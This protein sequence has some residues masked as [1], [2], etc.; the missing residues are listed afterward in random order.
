VL[1][2][3]RYFVDLSISQAKEMKMETRRMLNGLL[4]LTL[5]LSTLL[6]GEPVQTKAAPESREAEPLEEIEYAMRPVHLGETSP[7]GETLAQEK[8]PAQPQDATDSLALTEI[9]PGEGTNNVTT[10]ITLL[11]QGFPT[12]DP[13]TVTLGITPLINVR[14][15]SS[16]VLI[17]DVPMSTTLGTHDVAV[18]NHL[19]ESASLAAAFD[20][21]DFD[22]TAVNVDYYPINDG[23]FNLY[24][25][26]IDTTGDH[27]LWGVMGTDDTRIYKL[28]LSEAVPGTSAGLEIYR[29]PHSGGTLTS[30]TEDNDG[31]LCWTQEW[32]RWAGGGRVGC[33][34]MTQ[35]LS[36]TSNGVAEFPVTGTWVD[37]DGI[38]YDPSSD[39]FWF[40]QR[41]DDEVVKL[42]ISETVPNTSNGLYDHYLPGGG[43]WSDQLGPQQITADGQGNLWFLS[44]KSVGGSSVTD[45]RL[46]KLVVAEATP[47]TTDGFYSYPMPANDPNYET[48]NKDSIKAASDGTIWATTD[49]NLYRI[50]PSEMVAGTS[51]GIY[52][53][54]SPSIVG[55]QL[56]DKRLGELQFAADGKVWFVAKP[57]QKIV[58]F[59]PT[60]AIS[61]TSRGFTEY[62]IPFSLDRYGKTALDEDGNFYFAGRF[63]D[64]TRVVAK[65]DIAGTTPIVTDITPDYAENTQVTDATISGSDF[66]ATPRAYL[67]DTALLNVTHVDTT[68]LEATVPANM[69]PGTYD[70]T[71]VNPGGRSGTLANAFTVDQPTAPELEYVMPWQGRND[72][73][74]TL[75]I[76]GYSFASE[77][78]ATLSNGTTSFNLADLQRVSAGHLR[79]VVPAGST[80]GTYD[81][82]VANPAGEDTLAKAYTVLDSSAPLDDLHA[83]SQDVWVYT[84]TLRSGKRAALGLRVHHQGGKQPVTT[85]VRF[86]EGNPDAGGTL[87]GEAETP[88]IATRDSE[89]TEAVSWT[90]DAEGT[91][92]I[93]TVIDPDDLVAELPSGS[94]ENNNVLSR[95]FTVL[96]PS[97]DGAPPRMDD[98]TINDGADRTSIADVQLDA[99]AS[100]MD[101][102]NQSGVSTIR[103][104][105]FVYNEGAEDWVLVQHSDW[106]DYEGF[107]TDYPW[108][109]LDTPGVHYIRAWAADG[110]NNISATP[111]MDFINYVDTAAIEHVA[112]GGTNLYRRY[113]EAG[114]RL[115]VCVTPVNGDPDLYV[116]PPDWRDGAW[117]SVNSDTTEDLVSFAAPDSGV[118]QI[119]VYGYTAADYRLEITIDSTQTMATTRIQAVTNEAATNDKTL[120]GAPVVDP[121]DTP[122][123]QLSVPEPPTASGGM[124]KIYLPLVI[125]N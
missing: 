73:E 96:P 32:F 2:F 59:D 31:H 49:H 81:L 99:E 98:F 104:E 56:E 108:S 3:T 9:S 93:Y 7:V 37:T 11:G 23:S 54:R 79:G 41:N 33:L 12:A 66:E 119:E 18:E 101:V 40:T 116:W 48:W 35:V 52:V 15:L 71:V 46:W 45:T 109:M 4:V 85:T 14:V 69:D 17:A 82:T 8:A 121:R 19:G 13:P 72:I 83:T 87:I 125:S 44:Q 120:R 24:D 64:D 105:E 30:L 67:G 55:T 94:A 53:Y 6:V 29:E 113:L 5:L 63:E 122:S 89:N 34:T 10:T 91:Y 50:V 25:M 58:S 47:G 115:T 70:L 107:H 124:E 92:A 1:F 75:D 88:L 80:S 61:G 123:N 97:P 57:S 22:A 110:A 102:P 68:T 111:A 21:E 20:V 62:P 76:W 39:S 103:Y 114:D 77:V 26:L 106:L 60:Q 42:V 100:E 43:T 86:Y 28:D 16:T 112:A 38:T 27:D 118:Y 90:P 78:T 65:I 84:P 51:Q 74:V 95:T 36:S 117:S